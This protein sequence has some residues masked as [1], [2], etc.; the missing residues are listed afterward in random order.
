MERDGLQDLEFVS[1]DVEAEVVYPLHS[2][3]AQE[4]DERKAGQ[5]ARIGVIV[6]ARSLALVFFITA[7]RAAVADVTAELVGLVLDGHDLLLGGEAVREDVGLAV[8]LEQFG[9]EDGVALDEEALPAEL[10]LERERVRG[11]VALRRATLHEEEVAAILERQQ[12]EGGH[13]RQRKRLYATIS[14]LIEGVLR[15]ELIGSFNG[16]IFDHCEF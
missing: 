13:Q 11:A 9:D 3:R 6:L 15:P 10:L 12:F 2:E 7:G 16:T 8:L 5:P 14:D 4:R 1:L